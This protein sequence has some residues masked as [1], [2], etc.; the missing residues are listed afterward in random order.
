VDAQLI[1]Y[2]QL[3]TCKVYHS[4]E[5]A[6][7]NPSIVYRLDLSKQK[8]KEFPKEIF[9]FLEFER[10]KNLTEIKSLMY[11]TTLKN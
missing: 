5:E 2:E 8:L 3:D 1:E 9:L 4:L 10:L 11:L 7:L 6:M